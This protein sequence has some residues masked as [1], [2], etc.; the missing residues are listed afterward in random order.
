MTK[1]LTPLAFFPEIFRARLQLKLP[2]SPAQVTSVEAIA[3]SV[4]WDAATQDIL[5]VPAIWVFPKNR[6]FSPQIIR[7]N[8]VFPL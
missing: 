3:V 2:K 4:A 1:S 6:G 5:K 8:K 7:F